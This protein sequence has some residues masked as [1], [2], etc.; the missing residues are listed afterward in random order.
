MVGRG[1]PGMAPY[2]WRGMIRRLVLASATALVGIVGFAAPV[3]AH[4]EPDP[5]EAQAGEHLTVGF[6]VEHGCDGSPTVEIEM[7]LPEGITD[8]VPEPLDGW[9]ESVDDEGIVTYTGGPLP[10][11]EEGTFEI[12]M[13]M[14]PRPD[15]TIYFPFVQHCEVG[16][17]RWIG[18]PVNSDNEPDE[19][20]PALDLIGPVVT[21]TAPTTPPDTAPPATDTSTATTAPADTIA[22][23]T[24]VPADTT[25]AVVPTTPTTTPEPDGDEDGSSSTGTIV[26]VVSVIA[27][28]AI[29][30]I[31]Y[32]TARR[33]RSGDGGDPTADDSQ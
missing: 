6:T 17:I 8:V 29:A 27:V 30:A 15:T 26:F 2:P 22:S 28:L 19:P 32:V 21:T 9:D 20:A 3:S 24:T 5:S 10:A 13:T 1:D 14:P 12:T 33:N 25:P 11:D 7:R 18:L 4:I 31:A 23:A 16:E